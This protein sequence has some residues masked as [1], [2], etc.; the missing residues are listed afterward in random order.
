MGVKG[1]GI[2]KTWIFGIVDGGLIVLSHC[3]TLQKMKL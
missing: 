3:E 2:G 1:M